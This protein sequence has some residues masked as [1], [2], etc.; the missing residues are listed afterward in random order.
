VSIFAFYGLSLGRNLRSLIFG[1][2]IFLATSV[3]NLAI[4]GQLGQRFQPTWQLLQPSLYILVLCV[5]SVGMWRYSPIELPKIALQIKE[6]YERLARL[7]RIR[8]RE[9]RTHMNKGIRA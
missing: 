2:G 1:Y 9:L 7:T 5:W 8:L 4:R 6:D 3:I